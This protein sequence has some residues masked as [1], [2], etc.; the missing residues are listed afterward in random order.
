M[1]TATKGLSTPHRFSNGWLVPSRSTPGVQYF[2]N[3]DAT[4]CTCKGF[5][6][7]GACKHLRIVLEAKVLIEEMLGDA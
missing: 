3:A 5:A 7:R 1:K 2:V 4:R 6:Y